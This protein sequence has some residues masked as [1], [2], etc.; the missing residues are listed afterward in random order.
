MG[1]RSHTDCQHAP[2]PALTSEAILE[3]FDALGLRITRP[4][5]LIAE[6]LG[7]R[8]ESGA[9]FSVQDFWEDLQAL[10]PQIGRATVYRTV[11]VLVEQGMLDRVPAEGGMHRY[12]VCGETHH[13]HV[14]CS[15][16]QRVVE[17]EA[18]LPP[19]LFDAVASATDFA[20]EGHSLELVGRCAPCRNL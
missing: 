3:L 4:R 11:D 9:N 2:A 10:D 12:R 14:R 18:C 15:R 20:I 19:E 5:R 17:I 8:A 1:D 6:Q 7:A 16:C 13:H